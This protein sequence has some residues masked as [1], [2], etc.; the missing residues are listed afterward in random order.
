MKRAAILSIA[1]L[2][3]MGCESTDQKGLTRA[4]NDSLGSSVRA[5]FIAMAENARQPDPILGRIYFEFAKADLTES[6]KMQLDEIAS[7]VARRQGLIVVEGHADSVNTDEFNK[8]LG[9]DRALAAANYLR[10]VGV[11]DERLVVKSYGEQRPDTTNTKDLGRA[12]NRT[13]VVRM[14]AQGEG[15]TGEQ[16]KRVYQKMYQSKSPAKSST[17]FQTLSTDSGSK[18]SGSDNS[19]LNPPVETTK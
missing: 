16:A 6:A 12:L 3:W 10:N 8:R 15:M 4:P 11:W 5:P 13:V 19:G 9:Y 2:C 7:L 14:F 18:D 17:G 1:I